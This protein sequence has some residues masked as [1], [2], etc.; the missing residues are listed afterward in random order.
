M[1]SLIADVIHFDRYRLSVSFLS[2][3]CDQCLQVYC[4]IWM[5]IGCN[6]VNA[7]THYYPLDLRKMKRCIFLS[8]STLSIT[9]WLTIIYSEFHVSFFLL[10]L[11]FF[12]FSSENLNPANESISKLTLSASDR[13][14]ID[15]VP[16]IK[17]ALQKSETT[18]TMTTTITTGSMNLNRANSFVSLSCIT[19][20][21]I[22]IQ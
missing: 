22:Y 2:N 10:F 8:G 19:S 12:S 3:N 11:T 13:D 21:Y 18:T 20:C 17:D 9:E 6:G 14:L 1:K 15:L 7:S 4:V 5:K 16:V